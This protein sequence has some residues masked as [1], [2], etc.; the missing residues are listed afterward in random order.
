VFLGVYVGTNQFFILL[1]ANASQDGIASCRIITVITHGDSIAVLHYGV[2]SEL[3]PAKPCLQAVD[4]TAGVVVNVVHLRC[5]LLGG[6]FAR[7]KTYHM[8]FYTSVPTIVDLADRSECM[9]S[10]CV[11][12]VSE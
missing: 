2:Q 11:A 1:H 5:Y 9:R 7:R 10:I 3:Q 4:T 6:I 8:L 12:A